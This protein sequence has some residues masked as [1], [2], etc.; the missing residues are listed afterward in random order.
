[1]SVSIV[2]VPL[3]LAIGGMMEEAS[4]DKKIAYEDVNN[5]YK[6]ND[7]NNVC[8]QVETPIK[9]IDLLIEGVEELGFDFISLNDKYIIENE[10]GNIEFIKNSNNQVDILFNGDYSEE[11]VQNISSDIYNQ[12]TSVLQ[13]EV[14][15]TLKERAKERGYTLENEV[16]EEDNSIVLNFSV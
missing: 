2:L 14:Y 6:N 5:V 10:V 16:I 15:K 12:Y 3:A 1:M 11:Q 4:L 9:R 13:S 7:N 8:Y